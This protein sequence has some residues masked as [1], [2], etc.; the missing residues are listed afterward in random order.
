VVG[1]G[2]NV[3]GQG[4]LRGI[5]AKFRRNTRTVAAEMARFMQLYGPTP[6]IYLDSSGIDSLFA[7]TVK[8][9]ETSRTEK[10]EGSKSAKVTGSASLSNLWSA[11]FGA[12]VEAGGDFSR[13]S[14]QEITSTFTVEQKLTSLLNYLQAVDT[15]LRH[16]DIKV[17]ARLAISDH[18]S[19]MLYFRDE[20]LLPQF[21]SGGGGVSQV[22]E[23]EALELISTTETVSM[24][25]SLTKFT[26]LADGKM[27]RLS[28]EALRFSKSEGR[29]F[30]GVFGSLRS[31]N[32]GLIMKP[33]AIWE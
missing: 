22:N 12:K 1:H 19:I 33:Y 15:D 31:A 2:Q 4:S 25:A 27:P 18:I 17:A 16:S 30:L 13:K 14:G 21:A 24:V 28:H 9:L 8:R 26:R 10:S 7:Q 23:D 29:T 5:Y 11:L 3:G 20:F 6:F 32:N